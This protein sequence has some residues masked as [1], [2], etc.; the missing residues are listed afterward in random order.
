MIEQDRHDADM[1][2]LAV[3]VLACA[4]VLPALKILAALWVLIPIRLGR[5]PWLAAR[6]IRLF[7]RLRPWAMT[8]VYLLGVMVAYVKLVDLAQIGLGPALWAFVTLI[9]VTVA[10]AQT[11]NLPAAKNEAE[12]SERAS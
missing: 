1:A 3:V 11:A 4:V 10:M 2:L 9:L 8:E 6:S 12:P 5:R 7:D